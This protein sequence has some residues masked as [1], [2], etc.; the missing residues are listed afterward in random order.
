MPKPLLTP[1]ITYSLIRCL[2]LSLCPLTRD[3]SRLTVRTTP[4]FSVIFVHQ[5][6]LPRKRLVPLI[7]MFP[8]TP[9]PYQLSGLT[10]FCM[11]DTGKL[12]FFWKNYTSTQGCWFGSIIKIILL[13]PYWY[14]SLKLGYL[15]FFII[16]CYI[17]L[18][19]GI[20]EDS[21]ES[22]GLQGDPTSPS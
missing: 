10:F 18:K 8:T 7:P 6:P 12:L 14:I 13:A 4:E 1:L 17:L 15:A 22:L 3:N 21:L 11:I 2:A 9:F 5:M 20:G 16:A 19:F